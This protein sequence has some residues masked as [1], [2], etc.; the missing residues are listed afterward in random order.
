[1]KTISGKAISSKAV[2]L[3]KAAKILSKF[4]SAENG[5]SQAISAYLHQTSAAFNEL[6]QLHKEL[7]ASRLG[8]KHKRH[9]S[10]TYNGSETVVENPFRTIDISEE[11][12]HGAV[13]SK[14]KFKGHQF[15]GEDVADGVE[16]QT[17]NVISHEPNDAIGYHAGNEGLGEKHKKKKKKPEMTSREHIDNGF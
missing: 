2:S 6:N 15:G 1:M 13:Q 9:R 16:K 11:L 7:K 17:D 5:A 12:N 3:S 4:V 8:H 14:N 10:E